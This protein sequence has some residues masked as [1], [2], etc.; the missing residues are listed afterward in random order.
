MV[1]AGDLGEILKSQDVDVVTAVYG[2]FA[3]STLKG[4]ATALG[5]ADVVSGQWRIEA[6]RSLHFVVKGALGQRCVYVRFGL[7]AHPLIAVEPIVKVDPV[8]GLPRHPIALRRL[9]KAIDILK[10]DA[11]PR[12]EGIG[13]KTIQDLFAKAVTHAPLHALIPAMA[14][15]QASTYRQPKPI[16]L[17]SIPLP[18]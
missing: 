14:Y 15:M 17:V 6:V 1:Q 18:A 4:G 9:S 7:Y 2:R 5:C 10:I 16:L 3:R 8:L 11:K 13:I 12:L